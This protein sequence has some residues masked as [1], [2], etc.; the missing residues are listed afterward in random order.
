ML[1]DQN[2]NNHDIVF[3]TKQLSVYYGKQLAIRDIIKC[4]LW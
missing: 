3:T 4:L 2:S 1:A